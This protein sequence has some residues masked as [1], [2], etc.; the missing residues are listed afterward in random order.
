MLGSVLIL[1]MVIGACGGGAIISCGRRMALILSILIGAV[2]VG[3]TLEGSIPYILSGR[4]LFGWCVGVQSIAQPRFTQENV[5]NHL[6][7]TISPLF[8]LG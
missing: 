2:G 1:G 3:L 8:V 7:D 6:Y 5:P 4:L